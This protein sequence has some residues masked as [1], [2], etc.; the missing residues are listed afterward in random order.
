MCQQDIRDKIM[1]AIK[2]GDTV[3]NWLMAQTAHYNRLIMFGHIDP[4][5]FIQNS[6][7]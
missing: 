4:A 7:P 1:P 2:L 6:H 5:I 3:M